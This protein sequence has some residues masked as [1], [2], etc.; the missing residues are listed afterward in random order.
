MGIM[1]EF[2][3]SQSNMKQ[4]IKSLFPNWVNDNEKGKYTL[5]LT[6]DIDSLLSSV[7]L[8]QIKGYEINYFYDFENLYVKDKE[9]KKRAVGI[10]FAIQN[11]KTWDN[12]TTMINKNDTYNIESANLN[13]ILKINKENYFQK[14][15]MST[16]LQIISYYNIDLPTTEEGKMILLSIDSSYLG[17][18]DNRFKNTHNK[19][20]EMLELDELI[21]VLNRHTKS[22]FEQI[23]KKYNLKSKIWIN[24]NGILETNLNLAELQGFFNVNLSLPSEPFTLMKQFTRST[25]TDINQFQNIDKKRLFSFAL[26][27]RN[28]CKFSLV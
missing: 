4:E 24:Q 20:L 28:Y 6:D 22:E 15:A 26:T 3:L 7:L 17:H 2:T 8:Q 10:D 16:V 27:N 23:Q 1:W 18:Y 13:N 21:D 25:K 9:N 5:A 11:G 14:Y 19:Y 12:H